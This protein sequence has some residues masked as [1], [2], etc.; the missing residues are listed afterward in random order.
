MKTVMSASIKLSRLDLPRYFHI[1]NG[2]RN[3][4]ESMV[5]ITEPVTMAR[6]NSSPVWEDSWN[7]K[8]RKS[9]RQ[10]AH[11]TW[12]PPMTLSIIVN[13]LLIERHAQDDWRPIPKILI[14]LQLKKSGYPTH[15]NI[16]LRLD[17]S[18]AHYYI[19]A[20]AQSSSVLKSILNTSLIDVEVPAPLPWN[21]FPVAL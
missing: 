18:V 21:A 2:N 7:L 3:E 14:E 16:C 8:Q 1:S 19:L 11:Q 17:M 6:E 5:V 15:K 9:P 12:L 13:E 20:P 4:C 10:S